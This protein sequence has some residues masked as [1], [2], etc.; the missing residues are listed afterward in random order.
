[1]SVNKNLLTKLQ[2]IELDDA[3]IFSK[4]L[5]GLTITKPIVLTDLLIRKYSISMKYAGG[6]PAIIALK[7]LGA[8]P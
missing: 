6:A 3:F 2:A 5:S 4:G 7:P 8:C 1:M